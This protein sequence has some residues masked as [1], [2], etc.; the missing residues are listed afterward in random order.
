MKKQKSYLILVWSI[1][2]ITLFSACRKDRNAS[3]NTSSAEDNALSEVTFDDAY[4]LVQDA[5]HYHPGIF[6]MEQDYKILSGCA[7]VTV[8]SASTP[9]KITIDFGTGC[10]GQDGKNRTGKIIVTLTGKYRMPGTVITTTFDNYTVDGNKVEG[11]K[12]VTN[13]GMNS[14]QHPYWK[15]EVKNAKITKTDKTVITWEST[16]EREFSAGFETLTDPK[17]DEFTITG[18]ASGVNA[19]GV[20][21]TMN[22]LTGLKLKVGCRWVCKG[23]LEILSTGKPTATVDFGDGACDNKASVTVNGKVYNFTM[24]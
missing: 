10:V 13:M 22:I 20:A 9:Y 21:F 6:K 17:D 5:A 12:T 18:T 4:D 2:F 14:S 16:R 24:K 11:T 15:I 1:C 8:D 19:K 7:T 23:T 3:D